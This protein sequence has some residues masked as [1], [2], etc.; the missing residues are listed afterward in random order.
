MVTENDKFHIPDEFMK[1]TLEEIVI[2]KAKILRELEL[3]KFKELC[4]KIMIVMLISE[5]EKELLSHAALI[6][7]VYNQI[8]W[9]RDV[10]L[11]Q[12][13]E[14]G[15]SLGEKVDDVK[16]LIDLNDQGLLV[17]LPIKPGEQFWELDKSYYPPVVYSRWAH[18]VMHCLYCKERLGKTTFL[19]EEDGLAYVKKLEIDK[20][21]EQFKI[22]LD[23][24]Y[25]KTRELFDTN[26]LFHDFKV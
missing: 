20:I 7:S 3:K 23:K 15:L 16:K 17:E 10:A 5:T 11:S 2:E 13:Q 22:K 18:S 8:K 6:W 14:L 1:M 26:L 12:L 9:E 4:E 19:T 25:F 24:T 21:P